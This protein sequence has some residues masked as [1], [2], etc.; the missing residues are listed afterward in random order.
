MSDG[1]IVATCLSEDRKPDGEIAPNL[2]HHLGQIDSI[3]ADQ[4]YDQSHVYEAANDKLKEGGQINIHL[5]A[6]TVVSASKKI[7][8]RQR[9]QHVN[10]IN[11]DGPY[12]E[13]NIRL[14]PSKCS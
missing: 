7:A 2:I 3:T 9:D 14:L 13:K 5:R 10:F 12:Q 6:N 8:L 11:K 1:L 4:V